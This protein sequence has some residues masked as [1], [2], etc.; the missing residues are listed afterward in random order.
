MFYETHG[1]YNKVNELNRCNIGNVLC[2]A[3]ERSEWMLACFIIIVWIVATFVQHR[4]YRNG[5][6]GRHPEDGEY[7]YAYEE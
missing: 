2:D 1:W 6:G 4:H 7:G 3:I 5:T